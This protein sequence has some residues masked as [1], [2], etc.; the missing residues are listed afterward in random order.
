LITENDLRAA[1]VT[2]GQMPAADVDRR[3]RQLKE[4]R[5]SRTS[6]DEL[7]QLAEQ[8]L[9]ELEQAAYDLAGKYDAE[10]N[11]AAAARWYRVAAA[12]DFS[13][14]ALELAKVLDRLAADCLDD[15]VSVPSAREELD[16]VSES[17]RWYGAAYAAGHPESADRLDSLIARHD[18][19]RPRPVTVKGDH[20]QP[21]AVSPCRL[22]GLAEVM[23]CQLTVA[24]LHVGTCRACQKELLD[25]GGILPVTRRRREPR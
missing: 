6:L 1:A 3:L 13:D 25:H 8:D 11:L 9:P 15:P 22:G 17:A 5:R 7:S 4:K 2:I 16:L 19:R 10:G 24:S 14:S 18:P 23:R 21:R 20:L 12:S